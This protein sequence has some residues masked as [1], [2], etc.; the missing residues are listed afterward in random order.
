MFTTTITVLQ[1]WTNTT[2]QPTSRLQQLPERLRWVQRM[3]ATPIR[4]E[5]KER[6]KWIESFGRYR[7]VSFGLIECTGTPLYGGDRFNNE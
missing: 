7:S 6:W 1:R 4:H 2:M 3:K 5:V